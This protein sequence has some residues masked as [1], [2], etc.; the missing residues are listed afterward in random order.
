[1]KEILEITTSISIDVPDA[2]AASYS[3]LSG[4]FGRAWIAAL[5]GLAADVLDHWAL[6]LDGPAGHG[7][8]SLVLPVICADGTP[9]ALKLQPVSEENAAAPIGLRA[10][11]GEGVVRLLDYDPDTGAMLLERLD[12]TRPLSSVADDTAALQILAE[13]LTRLI[14]VPAPEGLRHL[15]DIAAAMLEQVPRAVS[16]LREPAEQ[17]LVRTCASAVPELIGEPGDRLLH[18]D[19]HYD[20]ILAG[21]REPWLAIDPEPLAG[22]PGFELLPALD[23]RW[24]EVVA[25]GDVA[26]AVLRRFDLL[27]EVL[28]LDRQRATGW[29]LG[30]VLQN[31]LWDIE[32]GQTALDPAQIAIATA[33]LHRQA[34]TERPI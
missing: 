30:R 22:D 20:N 3:K 28:G 13:L 29:T 21:Q 12:A 26:R 15:A 10:W 5:P 31:A 4:A 2:L 11:N 23:N 14:A 32:D 25:T 18:W 1:M 8:A 7:M 27:T 34:L 17:R 16:A 33:L 6:R 24:E 9:G 19:L